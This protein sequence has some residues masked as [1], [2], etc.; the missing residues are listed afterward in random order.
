MGQAITVVTGPAR[1]GKSRWAEH[2]AHISGLEVTYVATGGSGVD[3]PLW[4]A[5]LAL[6]RQRRPAA[7]GCQEVG[8]ELAGSLSTFAPPT[9]ALVDSLGSWV[10]HGLELDG[11]TWEQH[12]QQL[13]GALDG[14]QGSV[15]V[16]SEQAGWGV[17]PPTAIGGIFRDRLG[18]LEQ[19][20][21]GIATSG[22]LVV[23]G[24]AIDLLPTSVAV[25]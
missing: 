5:R 19:Q 25:P 21:M 12:C 8:F 7:W 16:V 1:S 10:A 18:E 3:D 6:H 11:V 20:V 13:L 15:I 23:A 4:Q 24:R 17:V 9:L 2:L 14:C 22:W